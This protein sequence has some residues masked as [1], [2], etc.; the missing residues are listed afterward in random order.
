MA[1]LNDDLGNY[2]DL[3]GS[4]DKMMTFYSIDDL[5][6]HVA[7]SVNNYFDFKDPQTN[8]YFALLNTTSPLL[9]E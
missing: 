2:N 9:K 8:K 3:K 1:F 5:N 7:K 4:Y 6:D